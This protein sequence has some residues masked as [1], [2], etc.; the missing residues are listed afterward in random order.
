MR[1]H[2]AFTP[3]EAAEAPVG[4]VVDVLRATSTIAQALASGYRRVVCAAEI[5]EA[6]RLRAELPHSIAGGERDPVRVDGF[7]DGYCAGRIVA[8]LA[9][10][11]TDA[12]VAA[13]L[14]ARA[15]PDPWEGLTAR[16]YGPPGLEEDIRF[17]ARVDALD[18]VPRLAGTVGDAAEITA[19]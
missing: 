13:E 11:R 6:M 15:Y 16:T 18:V 2:V 4:V 19:A 1:V 8:R 9:A 12:A 7:D 3:A 17:C 14:L 5:D 10:E